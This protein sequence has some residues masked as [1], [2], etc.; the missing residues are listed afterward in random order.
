MDHNSVEILL[1][2]DNVEDAEM[3]IRE[4]KK[5]NMSNKVMHV[6]DGEQALNF[7][8]CRG[9]FQDTREISNTPRIILLDIKMPKV[10][11]IEVLKQ[12]RADD[13]TKSIPVVVLTSSK[14]D[15]DISVCYGL[16]VNS[17][18]VK[19]VDFENF[20]TSIK[21]IGYYWLL[22]NEPPVNGKN[23]SSY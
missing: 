23:I 16:G 11:G 20:A 10:S 4:L 8:F 21:N 22:L 17:Y 7:I 9:P 1:V 3:T 2:E 19:P 15:P 13:R 12:I 5:H 18:I 6:Q 14:E